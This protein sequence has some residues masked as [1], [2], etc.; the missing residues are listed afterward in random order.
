M[1]HHENTG[2]CQE[3]EI[4][5]NRYPGFNSSLRNWFK[6]IQG[7]YPEFH[8]AEAGRGEAQQELY[9]ARKVTRAHWLESAH[10]FN[11]AIDT[12]FL[13][14]G[15]YSLDTSHYEF[16]EPEIPDFISWLGRKGSPYFEL[17]HFEVK[18]WK[19]LRDEGLAKP[20]E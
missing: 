7:K 17:P 13:I 18:A 15:K 3:C 5:F 4:I 6:I 19:T 8:I 16:I 12:F 1:I 11:T 9:F 10:N 20:V 2:N 14:D